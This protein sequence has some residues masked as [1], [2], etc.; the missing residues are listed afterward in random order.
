M[1]TVQTGEYSS[2]H[3]S[4]QSLS[5][6]LPVF[7]KIEVLNISW[8]TLELQHNTMYHNV[9][10]LATVWSISSQ[11]NDWSHTGL[12][13]YSHYQQNNKLSI[14]TF[15]DFILRTSQFSKNPK[16]VNS[17]GCV[18]QLI[19]CKHIIHK[20]QQML[21][22]SNIHNTKTNIQMKNQKQN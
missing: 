3:C 5:F 10:T 1:F 15:L 12:I 14:S 17:S 7:R 2:K 21:Y 16:C 22:F 20:P 4:K 19:C 8:G 18:A 9:T 6:F 11:S 13:Y